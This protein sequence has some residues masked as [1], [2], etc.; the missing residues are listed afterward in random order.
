MLIIGALWNCCP[1]ASILIDATPS[2]IIIEFN[3]ALIPLPPCAV[4][5]GADR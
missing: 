1:A 4:M 2:F 5:V 3:A